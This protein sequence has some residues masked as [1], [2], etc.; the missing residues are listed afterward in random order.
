MKDTKKILIILAIIVVAIVAAIS[1]NRGGEKAEKWNGVAGTSL[2]VAHL[3]KYRHVH[4]LSSNA[5]IPH[6]TSCRLRRVS[7]LKAM[8]S[9]TSLVKKGSGRFKTLHAQWVTLHQRWVSSH[10]NRKV[11]L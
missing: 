10:T 2:D 7:S 6:S 1:L 11:L 4:R 3:M 8:L 9:L 5:K